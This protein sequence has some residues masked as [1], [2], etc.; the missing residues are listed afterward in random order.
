MS[1]HQT[2]QESHPE[3][4]SGEIFL[5]YYNRAQ[6]DALVWTS[7]RE[8]QIVFSDNGCI[9]GQSGD[10]VKRRLFPV[11]MARSE[12]EEKRLKQSLP[13]YQQA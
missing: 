8:G 11:F 4:N 12:R 10:L 5:G 3:Q 13:F 1:L 6:F 2:Q 7:K 9:V